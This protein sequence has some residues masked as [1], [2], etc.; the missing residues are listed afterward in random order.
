MRQS[1]GLL[2][3]VINVMFIWC[4]YVVYIYICVCVFMHV[5]IAIMVMFYAANHS[6]MH[7][8]FMTKKNYGRM[9]STMKNYTW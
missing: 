6:S 2:F 9:G 7:Y 4:T 5:C 8:A 1:E 3:Y